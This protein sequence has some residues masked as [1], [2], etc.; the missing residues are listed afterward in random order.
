MVENCKDELIAKL[1]GYRSEDLIFTSHAKI[2]AVVRGI[3]LREVKDNILNPRRLA[4]A[5]KQP[6]QREG[7][8][9]Y[10]CYFAYSKTQAH[11]Y[12]LTLNKKVIIVTVIKINRRWQQRFEK[13]GRF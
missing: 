8:E 12:I 6:A 5:E 11:R 9:K 1:K 3:D 4:F 7:E 13:H 2:Q 10:D